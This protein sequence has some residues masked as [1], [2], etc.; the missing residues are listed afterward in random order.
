M[1]KLIICHVY[2]FF[3]IFKTLEELEQLDLSHNNISLQS[4]DEVMFDRE[5]ILPCLRYITFHNNPLTR[6]ERNFF[7][8][9]RESNL[10]ELNFQNCELESIDTCKMIY[11]HT[12]FYY[13]FDF[14]MHSTICPTFNTSTSTTI[15]N[16]WF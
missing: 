8:G 10:Q 4:V 9:L 13:I 11:F 12:I 2:S 7:Y 3:G 16:F 6:I 15:P 14:Q 5:P 1:L